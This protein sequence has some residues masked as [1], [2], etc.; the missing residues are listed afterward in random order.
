[1]SIEEIDEHF[2]PDICCTG[3]SETYCELTKVSQYSYEHQKCQELMNGDFVKKFIAVYKVTNKFLK[4][5][6]VNHLNFKRSSLGF[7]REAVLLH[8]TSKYN[9]R[10]IIE[11][12][13]DPLLATRVKYGRGVSFS[14]NAA[15]ANLQSSVNNGVNRAMFVCQVM[16]GKAQLA[17]ANSI[18]L[19][20]YDTMVDSS[21]N[22]I[23]KYNDYEFYPTHVMFY[24]SY[25]VV[26]HN[27]HRS[28]VK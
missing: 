16:I 19:H 28:I 15:Y 2:L 10:S 5:A 25:P 24:T 21:G 14:P 3:F 4:D 18:P 27:G 20:P 22:V 9:V 1:M 26:S 17:H 11:D 13:F 6:Y 7:V 8:C 12:N 23:V